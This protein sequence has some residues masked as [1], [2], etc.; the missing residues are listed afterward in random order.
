[1]LGA[2]SPEEGKVP[3]MTATCVLRIRGLVVAAVAVA[4][5]LGMGGAAVLAQSQ[6]PVTVNKPMLT[7]DAANAMVT[8]AV[9]HAAEMGLPSVV[10]VDD[11]DG[12]VIAMARM[13]N[14]RLTSINLALDKAYTA[15]LRRASTDDLAVT[16]GSNPVNMQ[17]FLMQPHMTLLTGGFP[18]MVNGQVVGGIGASG[19]V[20][21]QDDEVANAGLAAIA[22]R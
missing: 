1:M 22:G 13:D 12:Y 20:G 9:A 21:G 17:S 6:G 8:A 18:I 7:L 2:I 10:V 15:A 3:T 19:G 4:L 11:A 16:F 14:A 5:A